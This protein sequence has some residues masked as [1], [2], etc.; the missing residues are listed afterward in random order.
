MKI[1]CILQNAWGPVELPIVFKPNPLN[2]SAKIVLKMVGADNEFHFC[3]TTN[4]TTARA[5]QKPKPNLEHFAKVVQRLSGFDLILV[6]G[7]QAK[8]T[9]QKRLDDISALNIPIMF[10]P[11]P[12]SRSLS[13]IQIQK[14]N[15]SIN[16][17]K[18]KAE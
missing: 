4:V 5:N 17:F 10:V 15:D 9:V 6:C 16:E 12:A 14:I 7:N 8:E 18:N 3:N 2:K 13:N 1:I 11:H